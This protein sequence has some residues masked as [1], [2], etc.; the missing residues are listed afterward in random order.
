MLENEHFQHEIQSIGDSERFR[1]LVDFANFLILSESL[2]FWILEGQ[3]DQIPCLREDFCD[4]KLI[5]SFS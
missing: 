1:I 5:F 2:M 4:F 3:H